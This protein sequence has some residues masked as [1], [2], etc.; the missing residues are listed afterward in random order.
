MKKAVFRRKNQ[1]NA[2]EQVE[3]M[4]LSNGVP[5]KFPRFEL[6]SATNSSFES[7]RLAE[8]STLYPAIMNIEE[9][10]AQKTN[11][12]RLW[13]KLSKSVPIHD[14]KKDEV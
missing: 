5:A 9:T 8:K 4:E 14:P 2:G 7:D 12:P 11:P 6:K 1:P 13:K 10:N 3:K